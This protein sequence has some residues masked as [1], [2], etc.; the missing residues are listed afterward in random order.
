VIFLDGKIAQTYKQGAVQAGFCKRTR[1]SGWAFRAVVLVGLFNQQEVLNQWGI[2][3]AMPR[4]KGF[5]ACM[6]SGKP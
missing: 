4:I 5:G 1:L 3:E 2:M 6:I